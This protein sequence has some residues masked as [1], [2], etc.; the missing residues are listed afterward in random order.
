MFHKPRKSNFTEAVLDEFDRHP[1][2]LSPVIDQ[3]LADA[4]DDTKVCDYSVVR[5]G[6]GSISDSENKHNFAV[7]ERKGDFIVP[8]E[9][10]LHWSDGSSSTEIWDG[11]ESIYTIVHRRPETIIGAEIDPER[12]LFLDIDFNNNSYTSK[13]EKGGIWKYATRSIYWVQ[14]AI[15]STSFLM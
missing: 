9:V 11:V 7:L 2:V 15:Q 4:L 1:N 13:P 5:I 14:N 6:S 10:R 3:F 8:V 12:K